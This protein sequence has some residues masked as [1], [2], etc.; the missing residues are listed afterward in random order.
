MKN[1][2]RMFAIVST[3]PVI[4]LLGLVAVFIVQ[5]RFDV[6]QPGTLLGWQ[7]TMGIQ[8]VVILLTILVVVASTKFTAA[9]VAPFD[10]LS[11]FLRHVIN[12]EVTKPPSTTGVADIDVLMS[13]L[14]QSISSARQ[15]L[16]A[17]RTLAADVSHQL[18]SPLTA[19]SLRLEEIERQTR[20]Q[21]VHVDAEASLNQVERLVTMVEDL[22]TTW[23]ATSDRALSSIAVQEL[24]EN[25][26]SRWRAQYDSAGRLLV[27]DAQ[28]DLRALGT[29]GVEELVLS[30]LL[31]NSLKYGAGTTYISARKYQ[32]WILIEVGDEGEGIKE[33]LKSTLMS[34][35][36]TTTGTGLGLAWARRQVAADGGRLEL[37]SLRPAVFGVFLIAD[38]DGR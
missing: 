11:D 25:E 19:L 37:R 10:A 3:V 38:S 18:R 24:I 29:F 15:H 13:D 14:Y 4:A 36:S 22:L 23:R 26:V 28:S 34:Q 33:E 12:R 8:G 5:D 7:W 2:I 1:R 27:I 16:D 20:G 21:A 35:G 31:D 6:P 9:V 17:E 30:V 32:T